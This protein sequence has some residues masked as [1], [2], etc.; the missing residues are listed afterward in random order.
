MCT[1]KCFNVEVVLQNPLE[2]SSNPTRG[3]NLRVASVQSRK[4][5]DINPYH[6]RKILV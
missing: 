4:A 1:P 5:T 6:F 2:R 3:K